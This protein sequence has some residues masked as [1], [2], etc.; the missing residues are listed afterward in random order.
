M[1]IWHREGFTSSITIGHRRGGGGLFV[2]LIV[3]NGDC[4]MEVRCALF[5]VFWKGI[6]GL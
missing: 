4:L 3:G 2:S 5:E 1:R 6:C